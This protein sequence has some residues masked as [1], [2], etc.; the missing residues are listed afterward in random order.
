MASAEQSGYEELKNIYHKG[1]AKFDRALEKAGDDKRKRDAILRQRLREC[2]AIAE[3][4]QELTLND[5]DE[6]AQKSWHKEANRWLGR[7]RQLER[8]MDENDVDDDSDEEPPL[9]DRVKG[10]DGKYRDVKY[11]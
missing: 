1:Q 5:E 6:S 10:K 11:Y 3:F 7:Q 4:C 9:E 8:E 2:E